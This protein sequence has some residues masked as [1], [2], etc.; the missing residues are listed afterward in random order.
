M[1]STNTLSTV[2]DSTDWLVSLAA[3][4]IIM[5]LFLGDCLFLSL[6]LSLSLS[7][8]LVQC[9][10]LYF[11]LCFH[12]VCV[13]V[14]VCVCVFKQVLNTILLHLYCKEHK[15]SLKVHVA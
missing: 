14:C 5:C 4:Y 7:H 9:T 12:S 1:Q 11:I 13:C 3:G 10:L 15:M 2:Y 8:V 6:S